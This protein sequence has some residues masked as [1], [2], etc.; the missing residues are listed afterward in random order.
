MYFCSYF[1]LSESVLF[2]CTELPAPVCSARPAVEEEDA[3]HPV[4]LLN[5]ATAS[6]TPNTHPPRGRPPPNLNPP[7]AAVGFAQGILL[8]PMV[9]LGSVQVELM[10]SRRSR[11]SPSPSESC[12]AQSR[13][14]TTPGRTCGEA[15]GIKPTPRI[16]ISLFRT[17]RSAKLTSG[18]EAGSASRGRLRKEA[19][20]WKAGAFPR[21]G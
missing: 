20:L 3:P 13:G 2:T 5:P 15:G 18:C 11:C 14:H 17:M 10:R 9:S 1:G 7:A 16:G 6:L 4:R 8:S 21:L 19:A 12:R